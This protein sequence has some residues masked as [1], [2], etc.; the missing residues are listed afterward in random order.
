MWTALSKYTPAA[1]G[2]ERQIVVGK[3]SGHV[4]LRIK[5]RQLGLNLPRTEEEH[6]LELVQQLA[7]RQQC[8]LTDAQFL[9]LCHACHPPES[10]SSARTDCCGLSGATASVEVG[11]A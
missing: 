11:H 4:S 7:E 1:V 9:D 2:L 5:A 6:M 3:H 8:S 10:L